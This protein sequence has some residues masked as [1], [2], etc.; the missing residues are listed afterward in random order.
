ALTGQKPLKFIE[1]FESFSDSFHIGFYLSS[2]PSTLSAILALASVLSG[3]SKYTISPISS[4]IHVPAS[5]VVVDVVPEKGK[6]FNKLIESLLSDLGQHDFELYERVDVLVDYVKNNSENITDGDLDKVRFVFS[7]F[8]NNEH[9]TV[10]AM[11]PGLP[12]GTLG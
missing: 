1:R 8:T 10:Q 6:L 2:G 11:R 4:Q 7:S 9:A 3:E 12:E 5:W